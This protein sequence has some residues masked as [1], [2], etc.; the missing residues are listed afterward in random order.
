MECMISNKHN[1]IGM[2]I[3]AKRLNTLST[4]EKNAYFD[5]CFCCFFSLFLVYNNNF[6]RFADSN[7]SGE[8]TKATTHALSTSH[9]SAS[10]SASTV[11][12]GEGGS[13]T[14][15]LE[16]HSTTTL[17]VTTATAASVNFTAEGSSLQEKA[18]A[19]SC[20]MQ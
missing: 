15:S 11:D 7:F 6:S 9:A 3:A 8:T 13:T 12:G 18:L 10:A 5:N 1:V 20:N 17:P 2:A 19:F 4:T 14:L 16:P